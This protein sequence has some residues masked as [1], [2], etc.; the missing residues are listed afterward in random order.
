MSSLIK[1]KALKKIKVIIQVAKN[2]PEKFVY[3][4]TIGNAGT[5]ILPYSFTDYPLIEFDY[6]LYSVM[7]MLLYLIVLSPINKQ[8]RLCFQDQIQKSVF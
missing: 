4:R 7:P 8:L 6:C 5:C 1:T 2:F 3:I